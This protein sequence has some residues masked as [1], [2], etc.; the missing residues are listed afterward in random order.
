MIKG[1]APG[2]QGVFGENPIGGTLPAGVVPIWAA[3]DPAITTAQ[4]TDGS[5]V[6][7]VVPANYAQ[8][9]F[10]LSVSASLPDGTTPQAKVTV[11]ILFPEV[12]GFTIDQVS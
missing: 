7:C 8:A 3:S 11:P 10:V 12:N 5:E 2:A 1:I 6:T 9:S 4:T